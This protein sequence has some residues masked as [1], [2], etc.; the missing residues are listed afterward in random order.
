MWRALLSV[1]VITFSGCASE[2]DE[3][4]ASGSD[5]TERDLPEVASI[6]VETRLPPPRDELSSGTTLGEP[7]KVR[8]FMS[9]LK[10]GRSTCQGAV[11]RFPIT[12][13]L[14]RNA[15]GKTV[16]RTELQCGNGHVTLANGE[17]VSITASAKLDDVID[18]P[19]LPGDVLV[20]VDAIEIT[21]RGSTPTKKVVSDPERIAAVMKAIDVDTIRS[22]APAACPEARQTLIFKRRGAVIARA[23][24]ACDGRVLRFEGDDVQR[25]KGDPIL[26]AVPV[27]TSA[28]DALF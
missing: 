9:A 17:T 14:F 2:S 10:R 12:T 1:W 27:S 26:G 23:S 11:L 13:V 24:T 5:L 16:A 22:P 3:T 19:A 4:V 28:I 6:E 21:R 25:P 20:G 7:K 18:A 8:A 15:E